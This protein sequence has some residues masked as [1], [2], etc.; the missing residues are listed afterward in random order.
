M[1]RA[2]PI[3][4]VILLACGPS[5]GTETG[6]AGDPTGA[7]TGGATDG[8][9]SPTTPTTAAD[10]DAPASSTTGDPPATT[11]GTTGGESTGDAM[12]ADESTGPAPICRD[13]HPYTGC[14]LD[15]PTKTLVEGVGPADGIEP[16]TAFYFG[17][18]G[19][20]CQQG[21]ALDELDARE[22]FGPRV[23][24]VRDERQPC[25]PEGWIGDHA[26]DEVGPFLSVTATMT[27]EGFAGDW[28][29]EVP[30]DPPRIFG[31]FSGDLVGPFEAIRC[32]QLDLYIDNCS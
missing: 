10:T 12:T 30:D 21:N 11:T 31:H 13:W 27:V 32:D 1:V 9:T 26:V 14:P 3:A 25:G 24:F 4:L 6:T 2:S 20:A 17:I 5:P 7:A 19:W 15:F 22:P 8:A 18:F 29:S 23:G 16:I 28:D